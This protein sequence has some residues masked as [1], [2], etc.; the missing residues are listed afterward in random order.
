M[1]SSRG[2]P[3]TTFIMMLPLIV[4]PAIAMLKPA[5]LKEGWVS[6][7]LSASDSPAAEESAADSPELGDAPDDFDFGDEVSGFASGETDDLLRE[8]VGDSLTT[9]LSATGEPARGHTADSDFAPQSPAVDASV[10]PLMEQLQ[11]LG[12]TKTLWF[13]PGNQMVGFVSFFRADRGMVSYRFE[14]IANSQA[15]AVQDVMRQV[16]AWQGSRRP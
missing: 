8:V 16:Q 4:V 13:T 14:A 1:E 10:A 6:R 12:A 5:D 7:L 15:A 2:G 11:R 9:D 3:L